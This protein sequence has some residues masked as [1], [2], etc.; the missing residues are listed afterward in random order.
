MCRQYILLGGWVGP[1]Y[2]HLSTLTMRMGST[3][4]MR[5]TMYLMMKLNLLPLVV[6]L[7]KAL[8]VANVPL[9]Q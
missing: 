4:S 3:S 2:S 6:V 1:P 8:L 7:V 9:D 5:N